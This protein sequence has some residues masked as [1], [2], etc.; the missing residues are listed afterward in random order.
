MLFAPKPSLIPQEGNGQ[1]DLS[2][3]FRTRQRS[4]S[5]RG[6]GK[7]SRGGRYRSASPGVICQ[8]ISSDHLGQQKQPKDFVAPSRSSAFPLEV[9]PSLNTEARLATARTFLGPRGLCL[10][11][12]K[13]TAKRSKSPDQTPNSSL[14]GITRSFDCAREATD[15]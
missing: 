15:D 2:M 6:V 12:K 11:F 1:A 13:K 8:L 5:P 7:H 9:W 14:D 10:K 3:V 4:R